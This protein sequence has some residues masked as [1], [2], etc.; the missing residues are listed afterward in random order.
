MATHP[1]QNAAYTLHNTPIH[2]SIHPDSPTHTPFQAPTL[3]HSHIHVVPAHGGKHR[4]RRGSRRVARHAGRSVYTCLR[5][6]DRWAVGSIV[7]PA[8]VCTAF[9]MMRKPH[10]RVCSVLFRAWQN[11]LQLRRGHATVGVLHERGGVPQLTT[12][13]KREHQRWLWSGSHS[14]PPTPEHASL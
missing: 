11:D 12:W 4:K 14:G 9:K 13:K 6:G 5:R 10:R 8:Y 7:L 3:S 1:R 2:P